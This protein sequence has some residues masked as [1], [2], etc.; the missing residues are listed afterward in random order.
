MKIFKYRPINNILVEELEQSYLSF[1]SPFVLNDIYD[2]QIPVDVTDTVTSFLMSISSL[3][4]G[5]TL[6]DEE[7]GQTVKQKIIPDIDCQ[8]KVY[9]NK[10]IYDLVDRQRVTCFTDHYENL[11]MWA[12]YAGNHSGVCLEFTVEKESDTVWQYLADVNYVEEIPK[13]ITPKSFDDFSESEIFMNSLFLTKQ[14]K[15]RYESEKRIILDKGSLQETTNPLYSKMYYNQ[16]Y[17]TGVFF[18]YRVDESSDN[19]RKIINTLI[20]RSNSPKISFK[21][22]IENAFGSYW[23]DFA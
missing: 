13:L 18:G 15:W 19:F 6:G 2:C 1:A 7:F 22:R 23:E 12:H 16:K 11:P 17:L 10:V 21:R 14:E 9:F 5:S 3:I 4:D 8:K 20:S